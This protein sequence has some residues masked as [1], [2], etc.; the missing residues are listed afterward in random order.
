MVSHT[1][2]Y[3][4]IKLVQPI[5]LWIKRTETGKKLDPKKD[6]FSVNTI[7]KFIIKII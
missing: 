2:T 3:S 1:H 7:S 6:L 5:Y 4:E